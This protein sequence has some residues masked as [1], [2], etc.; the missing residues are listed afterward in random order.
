MGLKAAAGGL[1]EDLLLTFLPT[2]LSCPLGSP[3]VSLMPSEGGAALQLRLKPALQLQTASAVT[4]ATAIT[5]GSWSRP[6]GEG[7]CGC[8]PGPVLFLINPEV[9]SVG[10]GKLF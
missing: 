6:P 5:P 3:S 4:S 8:L 1:P 10:I 7:S 9:P 2:P